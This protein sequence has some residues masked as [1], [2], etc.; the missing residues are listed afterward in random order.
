MRQRERRYTNLAINRCHQELTNP[1]HRHVTD[2]IKQV[3]KIVPRRP[4]YR[5]SGS[6]SQQATSAHEKYGAEFTTP[7]IHS[8]RSVFSAMPKSG[9]KKMFAPLITVS[10]SNCELMSSIILFFP[11]PLWDKGLKTDHDLPMPCTA[12]A[13][14]HITTN[15]YNLLG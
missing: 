13:M 3:I 10:S 7:R 14:E 1:C 15:P 8:F 12:A 4:K 9:R 11:S 5:F 2:E 6:V